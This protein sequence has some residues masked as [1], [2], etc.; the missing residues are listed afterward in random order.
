M[1]TFSCAGCRSAVQGSQYLQC[2]LCSD[3]YDL[4]CANVSEKRF[5]NTMTRDHKSLWKCQA[6]KSKA[7]KGDNTNTPV[8]ATKDSPDNVTLRQ[9]KPTSSIHLSE[10]VRDECDL[11]PTLDQIRAVIR[12][13]LH[14]FMSEH[15]HDLFS[16]P[17]AKAVST[18]FSKSFDILS[19]RIATMGKKM[20]NIATVDPL[21]DA[22]ALRRTLPL[23]QNLVIS[24]QEESVTLPVLSPRTAAGT[25]RDWSDIVGGP[26]RSNNTSGGLQN[27][28]VTEVKR[29]RRVRSPPQNILRGTAAPGNSEI[30]ASERQSNYHLFYV[31]SGTTAEQVKKYLVRIAGREDCS[32][33]NLRARGPY[34]S[35]KLCVPSVSTEHILAPD[36]WPEGVCI[37]PWRRPF[38]PEHQRS[39]RPEQERIITP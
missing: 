34:A 18:V 37:K 27:H 1:P 24:G 36:S 11:F 23:D 3:R 39:F 13:E 2:S 17:I 9:R 7:P 33:E 15:M 30:Q 12:E 8:R 25:R 20:E 5:L 10:S 22:A 32:V 21:T 28:D 4:I 35:F 14:L 29:P 19:D 26:R 16:E 31:K 6:C 38:R